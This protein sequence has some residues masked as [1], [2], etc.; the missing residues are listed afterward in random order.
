MVPRM[1]DSSSSN[2]DRPVLEE[3]EDQVS[4]P[5]L[6]GE[7]HEDSQATVTA[8]DA[9]GVEQEHA[10]DAV[11]SNEQQHAVEQEDNDDDLTEE[12]DL[13]EAPPAI[14]SKDAEPPVEETRSS[15]EDAAQFQDVELSE[16]QQVQHQ[17]QQQPAQV[18][19]EPAPPTASTSTSSDADVPPRPRSD[20]VSTANGS[21]A[22]SQVG[23]SPARPAPTPVRPSRAS[24]T[25]STRTA[26]TSAAGRKPLLQGVLVVSAYE[27]IL[28]SKDARRTP[29]LKEAAQRALD[30]LK[31][32]ASQTSSVHTGEDRRREVFEP[33]RLACE[34]K[35][36]S[37]MITAL[38]AIG[39]LVSYG[40]FNPPS[41][42]SE[43]IQE[44]GEDTASSAAAGQ[45]SSSP[46]YA[47]NAGVPDE[48]TRKLSDLVVD[49]ICDC[50][51]EAPS[52]PAA[53]AIQAATSG[54]TSA[55]AVNLQIVKAILTIVLQESNRGLSIHQSS[56]VSLA[57]DHY[58]PFQH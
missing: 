16:S 57:S 49:T 30:I 20:T 46:S 19:Q 26:S 38:D 8:V 55:D 5:V 12:V 51:I 17:E 32:P 29:A 53:A 25:Y 41:M 34:T 47:D 2:G 45:A 27:T 7:S 9:A 14:P 1:A 43:S 24:S 33:L 28:N 50:F 22:A 42:D 11:D 23:E 3:E 4:S 40:F 21:I 37:I 31:A 56:L 54:S 6:D 15:I 18:Q 10:G 58:M 36:N 35:T 39:K 44:E 52:G 13:D 48:D